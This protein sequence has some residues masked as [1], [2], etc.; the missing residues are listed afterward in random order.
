MKKRTAAREY[1]QNYAEMAWRVV[2]NT[3]NQEYRKQTSNDN[4]FP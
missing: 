4:N 1:L 3:A 2:F